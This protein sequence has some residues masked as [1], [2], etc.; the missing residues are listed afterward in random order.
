MDV[1]LRRLVRAALPA[2]LL[3]LAF[4][5]PAA[6][7]AKR[8]PQPGAPHGS[9]AGE[10]A[11]TLE[12]E[13]GDKETK[14]AEPEAADPAGRGRDGSNE[15]SG[16]GP[17][18]PEPGGG[19]N[20]R[21]DESATG[22]TQEPDS[23]GASG[24]PSADPS[25]PEP[26]APPAVEPLAESQKVDPVLAAVAREVESVNPAL[27]LRVLVFGDDVS[28]ASANV[29]A[30]VRRELDGA[31]T[32][33]SIAAGSLDEFAAQAGVGF[34]TLDVP[35]RPTSE[36]EPAVSL[37]ASFALLDGAPEAWQRGRT[38]RGVGVA[39]LDSGVGAD[40][41]FGSRLVHVDL[42]RGPRPDV[43][44]HGTFVA[45]VLAG[46]TLDGASRGVAPGAQV[47]DV[48]V[49]QPDGVYT[50][51]VLA[52]IEWVLANH[53]RLNIRVVNLSLA[54]TLPSFYRTNALDAAVERLWRRGV[55]VVAAAGNL[56]PGS[57]IYAPGNDPYVISVGALDQG[58]T[59]DRFDDVAAS[60]SATGPTA[61]GF[62]KPDL[63]APG[64]RI[65]SL[66]PPATTLGR[67]AP[68][69][70]VVAPG[71][72]FMSG[73]SFSAPQVAGAAAVLLQQHPGW[74]PDQVKW[75]LT[76]TTR[77]VTGSPAG[78]LDLRRA[79]LFR[80]RPQSANHALRPA[81]GGRRLAPEG[82]DY[83]ANT[84]TANTWTA[85]T[86]TANTWTANT[87]TSTLQDWFAP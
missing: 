1:T 42:G 35:V 2:A 32:S 44:G 9:A 85:N 33:V 82:G 59:L 70:N 84:W 48:N 65:V 31:V 47:F 11:L 75:V 21:P 80:G 27:P 49:S 62:A 66:L 81:S 77:A 13:D 57:A 26:T 54:E 55:V 3:L 15:P 76:R 52:G 8:G 5:L 46:S 58:T 16:N 71:L 43:H 56:G 67:Q 30:A 69:A 34:V 73:T 63:L 45:G 4:A 17:S 14:P 78:T 28:A 64:R 40:P 74:T 79:V 20:E 18:H 60:F 87:W 50:S 36:T 39:V 25:P 68:A 38:G 22:E 24:G 19:A 7:S 23:G 6:T 72:A 83:T 29:G 12:D 51:D 86:W 37:G 61:D 41:A 10:H 53:R